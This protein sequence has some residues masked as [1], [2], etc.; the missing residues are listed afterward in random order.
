[1]VQRAI[2]QTPTINPTAYSAE[3]EQRGKIV[4]VMAIT[5]FEQSPL[6]FSCFQLFLFFVVHCGL[7]ADSSLSYFAQHSLNYA[8]LEYL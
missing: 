3:E 1:M 7:A 6:L 8:V 5:H 2:R 4:K